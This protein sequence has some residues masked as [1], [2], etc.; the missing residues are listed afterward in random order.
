MF[1]QT[2]RGDWYKAPAEG[3]TDSALEAYNYPDEDAL[4]LVAGAVPSGYLIAVSNG[5]MATRYLGTGL[6]STGQTAEQQAVRGDRAPA[7]DAKTGGGRKMDDGKEPLLQGFY[8]Y[9]PRAAIAVS[10]VSEYGNRKYTLPTDPQYVDNWAR[11]PNGVIRYGA[12]ELRHMVKIPIEGEYDIKDSGLSHR[13]QKAWNAM[14]DLERAL[15]DGQCL[16]MRGNEIV[17]GKPVLGTAREV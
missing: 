3:T 17:D 8:N 15:R 10:W 16:I 6:P 14:A 2:V 4:V 13:A 12:A 1:I 9:F 11:V 5:E 7:T